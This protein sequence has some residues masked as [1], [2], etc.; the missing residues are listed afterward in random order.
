M[1]TKEDLPKISEFTPYNL[2]YQ[3]ED[4]TKDYGVAEWSERNGFPKFTVYTENNYRGPGVPI[5]YNKVIRLSFTPL[6]L[7]DFLENDIPELL[8]A[9][10]GTKKGVKANNVKYVNNEKTDE[11]VPEGTL[12]VGID[13]EGV[14]YV[15]A[16]DEGKKKIKF[17]IMPDVKWFV[18][19]DSN[20]Q[21]V[22]DKSVLSRAFAKTYFRT[23]GTILEKKCLSDKI[24]SRSFQ[25]KRAKPTIASKKVESKDNTTNELEE[26]F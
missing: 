22:K 2:N 11:I 14:V 13:K 17:E 6:N 21:P 18:K 7:L 15:T 12:I 1:S 23:L 24:V 20:G 25:S 10:P 3:Y 16:I 9:E 26:L 19:L 4:E 5:N 8:K